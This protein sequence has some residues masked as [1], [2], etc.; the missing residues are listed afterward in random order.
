MPANASAQTR[1]SK[2]AAVGNTVAHP[3]STDG[4]ATPTAPPEESH[5]AGR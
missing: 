2:R 3:F 5:A 4:E 1:S